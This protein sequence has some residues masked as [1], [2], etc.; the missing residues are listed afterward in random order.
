[1][2]DSKR[3]QTCAALLFSALQQHTSSVQGRLT[4]LMEHTAKVVFYLVQTFCGV[5]A[6]LAIARQKRDPLSMPQ[7]FEYGTRQEQ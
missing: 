7:R 4:E 5:P 1:M 6:E 3:M 2:A